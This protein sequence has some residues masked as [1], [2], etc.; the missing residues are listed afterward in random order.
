MVKNWPYKQGVD[1][2]NEVAYLF[3]STR[4]KFSYSLIN[5]ANDSL[6]IDLL[7]N[8]SKD[9]LFCVVLLELEILLLDITELNLSVKHMKIL[10]YKILYDLI[11]KSLQNFI[12]QM[13][14]VQYIKLDYKESNYLQ[15]IL[16]EHKLL[17]ENLL[18]YLVFGA[19][20]IDYDI[21][22]F[23]NIN[24]PKE[25]VSILLEN[26]I[27]QIS[28]LVI[29]TLFESLKSLS[30]ISSF[31][32]SNKLCNSSYVS[33]RSIACFRNNLILQNLKHLYF[34]QPKAVYSSRYKVWLIS[35]SGLVSK[36]ISIFRLDD[37]SNLSSVQS[38]FIFFIEIQDI[39]I[40]YIEKI[41]LIISKVIIYILINV[42]ANSIV[43]CIRALVSGLYR[44]YK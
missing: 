3:F 38:I 10:N 41:L 18:C 24:T 36:Y 22:V 44:L 35:S 19:S 28:D 27:I 42:L 30:L 43:F 16:S 32:K 4:Q 1:L 2:N 5:R 9:K 8:R 33:I 21:F 25:H 20:S 12:L 14:S 31:L 29:F 34:S 15:V 6:Y 13:N 26:L 40:P 11:K 37:L 7:D 39:V 23:D 17:L